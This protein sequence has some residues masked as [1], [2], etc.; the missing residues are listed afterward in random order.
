MMTHT[1]TSLFRLSILLLTVSAAACGGAATRGDGTLSDAGD[2]LPIEKEIL[3]N[4]DSYYYIDFA[5]YGAL[6]KDL[7]IGVF[8]SGTGGLTVLDALVRFDQYRND[9]SGDGPDGVPDFHQEAFIYLADQAN[10]PYGNYYAAGKSDLLVEHIIKDAQFLL[11]TKYY[12]RA[13]DTSPSTDKSR[14]K[15]LVI[16]CNTATAY[17]QEYIDAFIERSGLD[18]PVIGVIN[19]G[20]RGTLEGFERDEDGSIGVFATVGTVASKGYDN[21]ILQMKEALGYTGDIQIYNQGGHGVAEAVDEV[22][23]FIDRT[24]RT[25]RDNYLGPAL[26]D[27]SFQIDR[28]LMDVYDFDFDH[29]KM[30]CDSNNPDDCQ[31][32]QINS[33]DNYVRYHLVSMME[34]IRKTPGAQPLKALVLGCTH[35][36]YLMDDISRILGDLYNYHRDGDYIY[37]DYMVENVRLIDPAVYTARE[38]YDALSERNLFNPAGNISNSE[39]FISVPNLDN[40]H[41]VVDDGK[42]FTY[43]YKYGRNAGEIQEYV[44]V[45]PFDS[46]NIPADI[47]ERFRTSIPETFKL[48]VDFNTNNSKV[49]HLAVE[50]RIQ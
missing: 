1:M 13:T 47:V 4:K 10:M 29:G 8:D 39:F 46:A 12:A 31:V 49:E 24:A 25:P 42:R 23:E 50:Q 20:A 19:A 44:K 48:I 43:D 3:E 18:I 40:E 36:P 6:T 26:D 7:K 28:T 14:I 32:L 34:K 9:G 37:R 45:V 41:V 30:L 22:P 27:A 5:N 16:A 2:I 33:A 21:T 15:A 38:L 17:G 35:Y 11:G